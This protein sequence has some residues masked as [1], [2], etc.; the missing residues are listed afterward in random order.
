M[1]TERY[2]C[3]IFLRDVVASWGLEFAGVTNESCCIG[4]EESFREAKAE[5]ARVMVLELAHRFRMRARNSGF[6]AFEDYKNSKRR[7]S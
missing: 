4:D 3:C 1:T 5:P 2:L 6:A 7:I